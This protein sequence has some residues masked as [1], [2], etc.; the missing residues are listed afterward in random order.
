VLL[1][2]DYNK[3]FSR[4]IEEQLEALG[5]ES[6]DPEVVGRMLGEDQNRRMLA[7]LRLLV[8]RTDSL[9]WAT[10]LHLTTGVGDSFVD[11]VYERA[12]IER[13]QF[14]TALLNARGEGFDGAPASSARLARDLVDAMTVWL[15]DVAVPEI[16]EA[17]QWGAWIVETAGDEIVPAPTDELEELLRAL[18]ETAEPEQGLSRYLGQ[19]WPLGK[20]RALAESDRVRV[21]TMAGAKGLT[22]RATIVA[23]LED[24][25]IPRQEPPLDEE[26]RLLYVALTRA[27]EYVFGTWARRRTGPTARVGG[28]QAVTRR[29]LTRFLRDGPVASEDGGAYIRERW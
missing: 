7:A 14:G 17:P 12:R 1:R 15:D 8:H 2:T 11:Y 25:I 22:V 13:V 19:I 26:R 5:I 3:H 21:M 23:A 29:T 16:E 27:R 20:D 24:Q 4:L 6:S 9:A 18:D 28:G 10:L